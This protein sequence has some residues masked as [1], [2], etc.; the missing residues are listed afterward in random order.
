MEGEES[1]SLLLLLLLLL[2]YSAPPIAAAAAAAF[3]N[4]V[5]RSG[6]PLGNGGREGEKTEEVGVE[7]EAPTAATSSR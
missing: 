4:G 2:L 6:G 7:E 5:E 3:I 1:A